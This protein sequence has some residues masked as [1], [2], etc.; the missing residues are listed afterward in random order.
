ML[1]EKAGHFYGQDMAPGREYT[2]AGS[3]TADAGPDGPAALDTA[4]RGRATGRG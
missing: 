2:I 3:P 1:A 4:A